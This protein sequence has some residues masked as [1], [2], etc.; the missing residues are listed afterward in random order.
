M[1]DQRT[2]RTAPGKH[3]GSRTLVSAGCRYS[4]SVRL[5]R[6]EIQAGVGRAG[7]VFQVECRKPIYD[8]GAD[9]RAPGLQVEIERSGHG[10]HEIRIHSE[11]IVGDRAVGSVIP[12]A[13]GRGEI[14]RDDA[15]VDPAGLPRHHGGAGRLIKDVVFDNHIRDGLAFP[16]NDLSISVRI[17]ISERVIADED[18]RAAG[19]VN[20]PAMHLVEEDVIDHDQIRTVGIDRVLL[21]GGGSPD[22]VKDIS[23]KGDVVLVGIQVRPGR[24]LIRRIVPVP[25]IS[26]LIPLD[27]DVVRSA[28]DL[29]AAEAGIL[30][31]KSLDHNKRDMAGVKVSP[32]AVTTERARRARCRIE[33]RAAAILRHD[34]NGSPGN[35]GVAE[36]YHVTAAAGLRDLAFIIVGSI[37]DHDGVACLGGGY[38][39]RD[40]LEGRILIAWI[41]IVTGR[42]DV[43]ARCLRQT[44]KREQHTRC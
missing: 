36:R 7:P 4:Q 33:N 29:N 23:I 28:I 21:V 16:Q 27:R 18:V 22:V 5:E 24:V 42:R 37:Q 41:G 26:N 11:K 32:G 39:A 25:D 2:N 40:V 43:V 13:A 10:I 9:R 6:A 19:D 3:A 35:T 20:I 30:D 8:A 15:A 12:D 14:V 34:R 31:D 1:T 17:G 38:T 44:G